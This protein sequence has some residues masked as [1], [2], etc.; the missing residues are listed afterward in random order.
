MKH[1][2]T[3][4]LLSAIAFQSQAKIWRINNIAGVNANFTSIYD[5]VQSASVQNGDTL[6]LEPSTIDYV[7]NSMDLSKKLTFVGP[8]YFLDPANTNV[9]GN[10]GLQVATN[11]A[12]I[13]F[14]RMTAASAGSKFLGVTLIGALYM[15]NTSNI[16]FEKVHF[17]SGLYFEGGTVDGITIRKCFFDNGSNLNSSGSVAATNFTCENSMFYLGSYINM[18]RLS[19]SNNLFRNNSLSTYGNTV[20]LENCYIANNIFGS[21]GG[22]VLTNSTIKNN[23]FQNAPTLPGTATDNLVNQDMATVYVSGNTGSIDSRFKLKAGSPAIGKGLTVGS[24][25]TP[26]CGAYGGTDP[27]ILSGIPNIP[28]IYTLTVPTSIPSG[29]ATMNI[30]FSSKNNN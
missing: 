24:V 30:T 22:Y 17:Y 10:P 16:T 25:V 2:F 18:G 23:L 15:S 4:L 8:G 3:L 14:M 20:D 11:E 9:P 6:Y 1:L 7:T 12:R 28:S 27:Y 19:G 5:A 29:T 13:G 21:A 26:D